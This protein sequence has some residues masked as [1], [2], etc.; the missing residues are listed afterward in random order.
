MRAFV[1]GG[2]GFVGSNLV[3]ALLQRG[4][5]VRVLRRATSPMAALED[6]DCETRVG[7]VLDGVDALAEA[8]ADCDWVFHTAAISDY[9]RYRTQNRLYR[10][11]V[12]GTRDMAAAAARA[13]VK[14]F[15]YTSS[16][17]AL[18]VP[19]RGH[20]LVETDEFN[21]RPRRFPYGHSKHLAEGVLQDAVAAGLPVVIVNPSVVIGPRDVNRIASAMLVEA[22]HGRLRV[23]APGGTNFVS[24]DD[25]VDGHI[26]AAERGRVGERY[27]LGGENLLF[28]DAFTIANEL[29]GQRGPSF[30]LPRWTIPVAAAG[31]SVARAVVGPRLPI[32]AHQMRLSSAEIF[33]DATKSH[34]ELGVPFTPFRTALRGAYEWYRDNGYLD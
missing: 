15:V 16:L 23:A 19:R 25:V 11:N 7:D 4:M 8:M 27:I 20:H 28:R 18:G 6:L 2:T 3:A 24:V 33:A 32:G 26:A 9:W 12:E 22:E 21:I 14:R 17:A 13:G 30:V 34:E 1:T 29:T 10:T 31:I 5:Q